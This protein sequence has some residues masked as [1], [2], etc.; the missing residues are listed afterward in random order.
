MLLPLWG[1]D[2]LSISD[3][4]QKQ[5]SRDRTLIPMEKGALFVPYLVDSEREPT[6]LIYRGR[7]KIA[8]GKPGQRVILDPGKYYL[9]IGSGIKKDRMELIVYV[10][11]DRVTPVFPVWSALVVGIKD[12]FSTDLRRGYEII[13]EHTKSYIGAGVSAE[14]AK[15]EKNEVWILK[16]GLYKIIKKGERVDTLIDFITVRTIPAKA[17]YGLVIMDSETNQVL[18]GGES[19]TRLS[20]QDQEKWSFSGYISGLFSFS[21]SIDIAGKE[22]Q[23]SYSMGIEFKGQGIY[24]TGTYFIATKLNLFEH[25]QATNNTEFVTTQDLVKGSL[26]YLYRFN[27][28]L[29]PY[30]SLQV[31]T[32]LFENYAQD[33]NNVVVIEENGDDKILDGADFLTAGRF[34]TTVIQEG[35][36]MNISYDWRPYISAYARIGWGFKQDLSPRSYRFNESNTVLT[37]VPFYTGTNGPEISFYA[38]FSPLSFIDFTQDFLALIPWDDK[39]QL[40]YISETTLSLKLSSYLS[41][42]YHLWIEQNKNISTK[43]QK[44]HLLNIQFY[45]RFF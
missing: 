6:Y 26:I 2:T 17:S 27:K 29:G 41:I 35:V 22:D 16:P 11:K 3:M 31:K 12:P 43:I 18:G 10:Y 33:T 13:D 45:Y 15:G 8:V 1:R 38:A 32:E 40:Y 5:L 7:R 14:E 24:D 39:E 28:Y 42:Q 21:N 4:I 30:L 34:S 25:F 23:E 36:G 44:T 20:G 9:F 37:R 19:D